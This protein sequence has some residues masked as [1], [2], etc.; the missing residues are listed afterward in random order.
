M[1]PVYEKTPAHMNPLIRES[2]LFGANITL[3]GALFLLD[4][5]TPRG[6]SNHILYVII[7]VVSTASRFPWMPSL[8]AGI[9][10]ACTIL[11]FFYSP[12]PNNIPEWMS[13]GNRCFTILNLWTLVWFTVRRRSAETALQ[14]ANALLEHKV[15]ARARSLHEADQALAAKIEIQ[16]LTE[17]A[18]RESAGYLASILD[19]AE[20][21]IIVADHTRTI[22]LFN[23]GAV[24]LF[25]YTSM[26]I[27]GQPLDRLLPN[28]YREAHSQHISA[29]AHSPDPSRR[30]AQRREVYGL[31][32]DGT[33]FP[34][35]ASISKLLINKGM[36]FTVILRDISA[37][38]Q[39]ETHLR[40]LTEQSN[41]VQEQER[42]RISL[43]LHDDINQRLAMLA[44]EIERLDIPPHISSNGTQQALRSIGK[45]VAK[46]S[47]D[48]RQVAHNL[49][50]SILDELGLSAAIRQ[51]TKEFS[52]NTGIKTVVVQEEPTNPLP[53]E[54]A[55]CI[56]RVTQES[57]SN[58][59]KHAQASRVELE[60]TCDS[61]EITLLIH[62]NG[63]GFDLEKVC[64]THRGLGLVNMQDR[65]RSVHGR[66]QI[67]ASPGS[68][69]RITARIPLPGA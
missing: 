30:M 43:E 9:G 33:E 58:I 56:H 64:S 38:L 20:D 12:N 19:I 42:H 49:H 61:Q 6:F 51:L 47:D 69:T 31:K 15:E 41:T 62:D 57:L 10:T 29:F 46:I 28:R 65:V 8:T 54:I 67:L 35:E 55:A 7:I 25:G 39:A 16:R 26:E 32:K 45:K 21:A 44:I 3:A 14:N 18:H 24:K 63:G 50:P 37:R 5:E 11:G 22:T 52:V 36:V 59:A 27:L 4:T 40:S 48:I 60:L 66:L 68:G 17:E 23:Q 34:A 2:L 13:I 1:P 53:K